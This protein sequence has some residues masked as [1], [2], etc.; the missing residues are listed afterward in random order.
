M[1]W[2]NT[3]NLHKLVRPN[4]SDWERK[5]ESYKTETSLLAERE[6]TK[7]TH[8]KDVKH[9]Q[10]KK[11]EM[12]DRYWLTEMCTFKRSHRSLI[13]TDYLIAMKQKHLVDWSW[14]WS[15]FTGL[16]HDRKKIKPVIFYNFFCFNKIC[17]NLLNVFQSLSALNFAS[18]FIFS[19]KIFVQKNN[20]VI[21]KFHMFAK[22]LTFYLIYRCNCC[23][24]KCIV[25]VP[26]LSIIN[27]R[28]M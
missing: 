3:S 14:D 16:N 12:N 4:L 28:V 21:L 7:M 19:F 20:F 1:A 10:T 27:Y 11:D 2:V 13:M 6:I 22:C 15:I 24:K 9:R 23:W 17:H 25:Y 5:Y 18:I 8:R 26:V